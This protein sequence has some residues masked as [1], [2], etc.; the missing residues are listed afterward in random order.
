VIEGIDVSR[1]VTLVLTGGADVIGALP[2]FQVPTPWW[3]D[4]AVVIEAAEQLTGR[5]VSILRLLTA[6]ASSSTMVGR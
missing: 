4:V 3:A 5:R 2:A 6:S 1:D